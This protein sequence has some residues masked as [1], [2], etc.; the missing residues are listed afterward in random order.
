M[1]M[2]GGVQVQSAAPQAGESGR[3]QVQL[4]TPTAQVDVSSRQIRA[5][6]TVRM[7]QGKTVVTARLL[8]ADTAIDTARVGGGVQ[9][10][11]PKAACQHR[12]PFGTGAA[13]A[14]RLRAESPYRA[15]TPNW[16][17]N[18]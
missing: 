10:V 7:S 13:V 2:S 17:A 9:A 8:Q 4:S 11:A 15:T 1:T 6:Q 5:D 16:L 3:A 18:V 12:T 14:C